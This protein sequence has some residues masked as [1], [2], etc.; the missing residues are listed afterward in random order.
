M[1][2]TEVGDGREADPVADATI[3]Q[4]K[5]TRAYNRLAPIYDVYSSPMEWATLSKRRR[6]LARAR[7]RVLEVGA[8]TGR[9][10]A[11][12]PQSAC[13]VATDVAPRM[14]ERARR[15][16]SSAAVPID[17]ELADVQALAYPDGSFDT[18]VATCV[19]CSVADPVR[20]LSELGRVVKADGQILLLEHVRPRSAVLGRLADLASLLSR[21]LFGVNMNRRTEENVRSAGLEVAEVR[22]NGIW[23]EIVALPPARR[24]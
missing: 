8:G 24:R 2:G 5:V 13:V 19:F 10:F 7:G 3:R 6:L 9:S 15:R 4:D 1:S 12:Y 21:R 14:I 22:R 11:Y 18:A 23:R 20:G 16:A 17:V